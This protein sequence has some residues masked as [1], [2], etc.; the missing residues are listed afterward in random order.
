MGLV[1]WLA[2][3]KVPNRATTV[4][5]VGVVYDHGVMFW[6]TLFCVADKISKVYA[7]ALALYCALKLLQTLV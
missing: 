6:F 2:G 5:D 4:L 7:T 1:P 3:N